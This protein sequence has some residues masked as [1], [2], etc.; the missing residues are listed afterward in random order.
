VQCIGA[1]PSVV[2]LFCKVWRRFYTANGRQAG[3]EL[4]VSLKGCSRGRLVKVADCFVSCQFA[5]GEIKQVLVLRSMIHRPV[6]VA[7]GRM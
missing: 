7:V 1:V 3:A 4:R 6:V 2:F 5:A